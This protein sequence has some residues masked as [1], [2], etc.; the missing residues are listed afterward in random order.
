MRETSYVRKQAKRLMENGHPEDAA[1]LLAQWLYDHPYDT[2]ARDYLAAAY[3][4]M[5][6][7]EECLEQLERVVKDWPDKSRCWRNMAAVLRKLGRADE[8]YDAIMEALRLAPEDK[9]AQAELAKIR[10]LMRLPVCQICG[11]PIE[12]IEEFV[13][14]GCGWKY[15]DECWRE[16]GGCL[17]PACPRGSKGQA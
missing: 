13:C 15:H 12:T 17:N 2:R 6:A 7:Y 3:Y 10:Q 4:H 8:A 9:I 14:P 5:G 1:R 11:L 16:G